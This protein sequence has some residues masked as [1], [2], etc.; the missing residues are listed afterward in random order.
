MKI[1]IGTEKSS[2]Y[3]NV[4]GSYLEKAV[5][6]M[7]LGE[8]TL[9]YP[10]ALDKFV[11]NTN[12]AIPEVIIGVDKNIDMILEYSK[13]EKKDYS[14]RLHYCKGSDLTKDSE[15]SIGW[16]EIFELN[17]RSSRPDAQITISPDGFLYIKSDNTYEKCTIE[18]KSEAPIFERYI[19]YGAVLSLEMEITKEGKKKRL[20]FILDP[21]MKVSS[22]QG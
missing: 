20:Y 7:D 5:K 17:D 22:N 6:Y 8:G 19:S 9:S 18:L 11:V 3:L 2:L 21:L 16:G 13:D 10:I 14:P 4:L 1:K 12:D 15:S